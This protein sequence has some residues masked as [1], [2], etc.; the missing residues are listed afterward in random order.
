[1]SAYGFSFGIELTADNVLSPYFQDHFGQGA[2]SAGDIAAVFGLFNIIS[3]PLGEPTLRLLTIT[4]VPARNDGMQTSLMPECPYLAAIQKVSVS[5]LDLR[6]NRTQSQC[7]VP[8]L[9][10]C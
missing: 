7:L 6:K 1:M 10:N 2:T 3:R 5:N 9:W 8:R 4:H